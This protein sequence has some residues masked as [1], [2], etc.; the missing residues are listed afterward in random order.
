MRI[1]LAT[2]NT[3]KCEGEYFKRL[4]LFGK[5]LSA[6]PLDVLCCQEV[7]SLCDDTISTEKYLK[8]E[9]A[10]PSFYFPSR[11]KERFIN[12]KKLLSFSGLCTYTNS[13]VL[14]EKQFYLST[15]IHDGDRTAQV[16]IV[17]KEGRK[18]A[19]IN[20]HLTHLKH[21]SELRV[22]QM[23]EILRHINFDGYDIVFICGDLNDIPESRVIEK[24]TKEYLFKSVL[25][26]Y[27]P[28]MGDKCIDYIFYKSK[29]N[30][31]VLEAKLIL[32]NSEKGIFPSDHFGVLATFKF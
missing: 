30:I 31:D 13:L 4:E 29:T 8:K 27:P 12:N 1:T 11:K 14:E 15:H 7:F 25:E 32:N 24:L 2:I 22:R 26:N 21:E 28:T 17:I 19:I 5:Q 20:T 6:Y 16:L 10:L 23:T 9:L 18:I 3:W